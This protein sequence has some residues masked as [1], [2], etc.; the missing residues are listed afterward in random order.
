MPAIICWQPNASSQDLVSQDLIQGLQRALDTSHL[1]YFPL[2]FQI[3][4]VLCSASQLMRQDLTLGCSGHIKT[5][6]CA[7][8]QTLHPEMEGFSGKENLSPWVSLVQTE[9]FAPLESRGNEG[10]K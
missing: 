8:R 7:L 9:N 4:S 10:R 2:L 3:N 6:S 1:G 5:F